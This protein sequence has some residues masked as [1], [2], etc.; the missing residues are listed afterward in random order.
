MARVLFFVYKC[1]YGSLADY[2]NL[3]KGHR[4][5]VTAR[6]PLPRLTINLTIKCRKAVHV[7]PFRVHRGMHV[8][9][10]GGLYIRMTQ[11]FAQAFHVYAALDTVRG[12]RM[13]QDMEIDIG[14]PGLF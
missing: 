13:P 11:N 4:K 7:P 8:K 14:Q 3:R 6:L 9:A 1:Y 5:H 12:K 2:R 10:Q